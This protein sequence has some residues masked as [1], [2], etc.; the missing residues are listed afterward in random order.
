[1]ASLVRK[2]ARAKKSKI[3]PRD[4]LTEQQRKEIEEAFDILDTDGSGQSPSDANTK[5]CKTNEFLCIRAH[6]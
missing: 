1:M 6:F 3:P 5:P 4:T 2:K